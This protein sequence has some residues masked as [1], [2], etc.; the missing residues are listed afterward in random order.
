MKAKTRYE[1]ALSVGRQALL[2]EKGFA[3]MRNAGIRAIELSFDEYESM[4]FRQVKAAAQNA[5]VKLWSLHLPF[6]P[7]EII[8]ISA[9][10]DKKRADNIRML[11]GIMEKA[12]GIGIDT[13]VIHASGEPVLPPE[14]EERMKR[15][16]D[17]LFSL[18]EFAKTRGARI[19]VENLPRTCLGNCS[20]EINRLTAVN[21]NLKVCFDT[22][23][24]FAESH[25][26]FV[27]NL[28]EEIVTVHIS[29]YD[30]TGEKHWLPTVGKIDWEEVI[31][32]LGTVGYRGPFLYEVSFLQRTADGEK[33][34]T[35]S[36]F[37]Q[38][39]D[40]LFGENENA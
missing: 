17:S 20:G 30:F 15:S 36:D 8:D 6:M 18:S 39:Y 40:N 29:D 26:E 33:Q 10:D 5:G 25:K 9:L 28:K 27:G 37:K 14:R 4:D 22:N 3:D 13:F 12:C 11:C 32:L 19:A 7:F 24:L 2:G 34:L 35:L 23:H 1:F 21:D 31:G 16:C 38:N